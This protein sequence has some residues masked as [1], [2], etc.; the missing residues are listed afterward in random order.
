MPLESNKKK[1]WNKLES[2][3]QSIEQTS[4]LE[5]FEQEPKRVN[6]LFQNFGKYHVDFSKQLVNRSVINGLL[7][8]ATQSELQQ[9]ISALVSGS[10]VNTSEERPA[11]HS[12]LRLPDSANLKVDRRDVVKDVHRTLSDVEKIVRK[13]H[14]GQWRGYS[15]RPVTDIV[16]IGVGGSDLG[17][18]MVTHALKDFKTGSRVNLDFHFVSSMDGTQIFK[19]LDQL[20]P[21]T[22]LF[23]IS[24]KSFTTVDTFYNA[25]TAIE[26]MLGACPNRSLVLKQ[27]FIGVSACPDKM[28]S[29]GISEENQLL[30]WDWVGGRFSLW[31]AIGLPIALAIG[32]ENF[33]M[34]LAGAHEMDKHFASAPFESNLPVLL[35]LVGVWN[36][37]FLNI[38]AH[39]V[40]PYDGRLQYLPNYLTQLEMESNGKAVTKDGEKVDYKT[41]P[42]LWGDIGPN[43]Q[44]AFYQLLHQGTQKVSCDFIAPIK[45]YHDTKNSSG[46][47]EFLIKQHQLSLANCLAQSRVLAFGNKAVST[48]EDLPAYKFYKG[49]QPSTTILFN[50]LNPHTLGG[51]IAMYEHKV[52][53]MA[54]IWE[55]NPFDQWGVE[56]GKV[57]ASEILESIQSE[58]NNL[59]SDL[60]TSALLKIIKAKG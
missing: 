2:L 51:L 37:T 60:S 22:C 56:L 20:N 25:N 59:K 13:V 47:E 15:G 52:Y 7:E 44:H 49:N 57:I 31:S 40:L 53:V 32:M 35:G 1:A 43:A 54:M 50:E 46:T 29:W 27:H 39:T 55:I 18:F 12:A 4:L 10:P 38:N 16:N 19:L 23:I 17:P 3:A 24:S 45:R 28:S 30:F 58:E 6:Y 8:L 21:E 9:K 36:A 42:I 5:L 33:E 41:C 14:K 48:A 34:L 26:W 11:L